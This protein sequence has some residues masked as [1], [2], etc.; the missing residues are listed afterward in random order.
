MIRSHVLSAASGGLSESIELVEEEKARDPKGLRLA[1]NVC[2][3][4]SIAFKLALSSAFS[5]FNLAF[6]SLRESSSRSDRL[7]DSSSAIIAP[8]R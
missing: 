5:L 2:S 6:S 4:D 7:F 8:S 1:E 3:R